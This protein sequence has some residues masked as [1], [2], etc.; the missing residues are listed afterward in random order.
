[1]LD[2]RRQAKHVHGHVCADILSLLR[3]ETAGFWGFGMGLDSDGHPLV[4]VIASELQ[5]DGAT[6]CALQTALDV[7]LGHFACAVGT[8]HE[9]S[10]QTGMLEL[11]VQRGVPEQLLE[12]V[13]TIPVGKGM[14]G[15]AA[16]RREPVQVCNLQTDS[17]GLAKPAARETQM[18]GS[19]AVP[20]LVGEA[21]CGTLGIAK[22]VVHEFSAGERALL[23]NIAAAIGRFLNS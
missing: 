23:L 2:P 10:P 12:R 11:R 14:A 5:R 21:L 17:S 4:G 3:K 6:D 22:P 20:I 13:R 15:L 9:L 1:M 7:V 8:I 16:L 18:E 19:I